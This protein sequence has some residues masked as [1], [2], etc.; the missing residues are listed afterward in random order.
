M[1][2]Q[3][4]YWKLCKYDEIGELVFLHVT[5]KKR[6][7][8]NSF[9]EGG[10]GGGGVFFPNEKKLLVKYVP[11]NYEICPEIFKISMLSKSRLVLYC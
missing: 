6:F 1:N 10:A 11:G 9:D 3:W 2:I 8:S 4:M 5:T 7:G